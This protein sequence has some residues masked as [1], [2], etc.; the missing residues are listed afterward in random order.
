MKLVKIL[1]GVVLAS[2]VYASDTD[3]YNFCG[4]KQVITDPEKSQQFKDLKLDDN[5]VIKPTAMKSNN[6]NPLDDVV[7]GSGKTLKKYEVKPYTKDNAKTNYVDLPEMSPFMMAYYKDFKKTAIPAAWV[8][9]VGDGKTSIDHNYQPTHRVLE[10]INFIFVVKGAKDKAQADK[11]VVDELEKTSFTKEYSDQHSS[12]YAGL[13]KQGGK[14]QIFDQIGGQVNGDY[15]GYTFEDVSNPDIGGDHFRVLGPLYDKDQGAYVYSASL[16]KESPRYRAKGYDL[17]GHMFQSFNLA[18][19]RL[20]LDLL[21]DKEV[22]V[23]TTNL[24]TTIANDYSGKYPSDE[25]Y[26]TGDQQV[27]DN[28]LTDIAFVAVFSA[29]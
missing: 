4:Y 12:G 14:L 18:K 6:D 17:C 3:K 5:Y 19:T 23:Y 21:N 20:A 24:H 13:F 16:S 9:W 2:S 26:L 7:L 1:S 8:Y 10:V 27:T 25:T 22:S 28:Q 11:T 29:K 15:H